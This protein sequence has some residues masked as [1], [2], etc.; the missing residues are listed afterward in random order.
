MTT[1]KV[2]VTL[3]VSSINFESETFVSCRFVY[4]EMKYIPS[5]PKVKSLANNVIQ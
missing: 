2:I 1:I 5:K 3:K 4:C